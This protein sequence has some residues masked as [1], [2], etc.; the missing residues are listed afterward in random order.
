MDRIACV[1]IPA[2]PL[3]LLLRKHPSWGAGPV[4]VVDKDSPTGL[5]RH[6]NRAA[7]GQRVRTGMRYAAALSVA[8]TLKADV[9][10]EAAV[11]EGVLEITTAL[12]NFSPRVESPAAGPEALR[13]PSRPRKQ[14]RSKAPE[15]AA[16]GEGLFYLDASGLCPL[17]DTLFEWAQ[18][19]HA[20]LQALTLHTRV[21]VGFTRFGALAAARSIGGVRV[22]ADMEEE[23]SHADRVPLE[24][25]G[26]APKLRDT[27]EQL[28]VLTVGAF[29]SLPGSGVRDRLG[30]EAWALHRFATDRVFSPLVVAPLLEPVE[31]RVRFD[32]PVD[33]GQGLLFLASRMTGAVLDTLVGRAQ[34]VRSLRLELRTEHGTRLDIPIV[35]A[36]PTR[37]LAALRNLLVLRFERLI[38]GGGL[39]GGVEELILHAEGAPVDREQARL[40]Q[41]NA[42]RDLKAAARALARIQAAFGEDAVRRMVLTEGHLPEARYRLESF[43]PAV[44]HAGASKVIADTRRIDVLHP[45]L[46]RRLLARVEVLNDP[47]RH[48]RD[49]GWLP[50]GPEAGPLVRMEGPFLISGGWWRSE[51]H[52]EYHVAELQGGDLLWMYRDRTRRRYVLQGFVE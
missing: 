25:I 12:Q 32:L 39:D 31:E 49:N 9:V 46:V 41:E 50:L 45:P 28:G 4:A 52:R 48:G 13:D 40:F 36:I 42:R 5:I 19:V 29:L 26:V 24:R 17:Y 22:F 35:P 43:P 2:L 44:F 8:R 11:R 18:A 30:D 3:Q 34:A 27:L 33:D 1:D 21:A 37:D 15:Q 38:E 7:A 23:R 6:V 16:G 47:P 20:A 14:G 51:V 10:S